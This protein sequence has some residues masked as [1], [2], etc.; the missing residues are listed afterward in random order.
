MNAHPTR[1]AVDVS[2]NPR[3]SER[4]SVVEMRLHI[5]E[6]Y[7]KVSRLLVIQDLR[8]ARVHILAERPEIIFCFV[9]FQASPYMKR[10]EE[11]LAVTFRVMEFLLIP[12]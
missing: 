7:E 11:A 12:R 10:H 1:N 8:D 6:S 5:I 3:R 9:A 2:F 4:F